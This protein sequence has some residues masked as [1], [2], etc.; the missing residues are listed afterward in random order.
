MVNA[1]KRPSKPKLV[2]VHAGDLDSVILDED[3]R[4]GEAGTFRNVLS[5]IAWAARKNQSVIRPS[6]PAYRNW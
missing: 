3:E 5:P 4:A 6:C 1:K 2:F